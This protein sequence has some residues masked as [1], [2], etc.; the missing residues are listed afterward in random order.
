[1]CG[2]GE[3]RTYEHFGLEEM[4]YTCVAKGGQGEQGEKGKSLPASCRYSAKGSEMATRI[5]KINCDDF[6]RI[7]PNSHI[8]KLL[9]KFKNEAYKTL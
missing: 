8:N 5:L 4:L 1:M 6:L 7:T 3:V 2:I 9:D